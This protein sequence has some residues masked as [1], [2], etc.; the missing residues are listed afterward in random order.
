MGLAL[1][2][3]LQSAMPSAPLVPIPTDFNLATYR[4]AED[5]I[6]D[7][8]RCFSQ[9]PAEIVV[10]GRRRRGEAYPYDENE[11]KFTRGPL[12]AEIGIGGSA[13]GRAYVEGVELAPGM[14]SNRM[15]VG[16]KLPF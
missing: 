15:M 4:P 1:L 8:R 5:E 10:C 2:V 14:R 11:R 12:V 9:D 13:T 16:I 7:G 3:A 6:G